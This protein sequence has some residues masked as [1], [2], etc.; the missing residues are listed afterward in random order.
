MDMN[1]RLGRTVAIVLRRALIALPIAIGPAVVLLTVRAMASS[2]AAALRAVSARI[3]VIAL[4]LT[5]PWGLRALLRPFFGRSILGSFVGA[6]FLALVG[7]RVRARLLVS[8][9]SHLNA[10]LG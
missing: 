6:R 5:L 9:G 10:R 3:T 4:V 1:R 2:S 7:S 8:L